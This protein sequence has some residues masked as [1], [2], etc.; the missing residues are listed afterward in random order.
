MQALPGFLRPPEIVIPVPPLFRV[1]INWPG[2]R[3]CRGDGESQLLKCLRIALLG[4]PTN[5]RR[6]RLPRNPRFND[7]QNWTVRVPTYSPGC[8]V[9]SVPWNRTARE[10]GAS[11][12]VLGWIGL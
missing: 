1:I 9:P 12:N 6:Q 11:P 5:A 4:L 3:S 10:K 2:R 8:R 7:M